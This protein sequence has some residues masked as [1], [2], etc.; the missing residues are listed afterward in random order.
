MPGDNTIEVKLTPPDL[1]ERLNG[2]EK[3]LE[4][5]MKLAMIRSMFHVQDSVPS[6]PV[7]PKPPSTYDRTGTLGR[8]LT[9]GH[10]SHVRSVKNVGDG[11]VEGQFGTRLEYAPFVIGDDTQARHMGH[12]WTMKTVKAKAEKGIKRIFDK[13]GDKLAGWIEGKNG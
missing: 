2:Y 11:V 1:L 12:W 8:T 9:A 6:Y 5:E 7:Y 13:M 10:P 3:R 4:G